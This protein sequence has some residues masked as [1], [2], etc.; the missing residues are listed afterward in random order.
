MSGNFI[1]II[2]DEIGY[3]DFFLEKA[4]ECTKEIL[5]DYFLWDMEKKNKELAVLV[6]LE[7]IPLLIWNEK[8]FRV[9]Q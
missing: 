9:C 1:C 2:F 7:V 5:D 4:E 6:L 8:F 3:K